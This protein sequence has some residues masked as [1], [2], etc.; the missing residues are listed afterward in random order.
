MT[1]DLVIFDCDGVLVDTE[2]VTDRIISENLTR[3]G[4]PITPHDVHHL[5]AGGTM[6]GVGEEA[7]R[8]GVVLPDGWVDQIYEEVFA[9]LRKGV[10][11]IEGVIPLLD[12]LQRSGIQTAVASN[13][14]IPK[15]EITLKPS[16]LWERLDGRIYSGHDHGAKPRPDMLL[17]IMSDL[18]VSP[19]Q[20]V[21]VDDMPAGFLAAQAAGVRCFGYVADGDPTRIDG[22]EAIP[23]TSMQQITDLL[24]L[25]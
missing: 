22:M 16:G 11:V 12:R 8:R 5:F 17:K 24:R 6:K 25:A 15:M 13:G 2:I 20:T 18:G 21:M 4:L 14:P 1:P 9:D 19:N 3:H 7:T 23:V 10:D